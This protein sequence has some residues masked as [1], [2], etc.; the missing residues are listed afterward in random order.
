MPPPSSGGIAVAP[1]ANMLRAID[2]R[3]LGWHSAAHVHQLVEVWRRAFA[4]RN[5]LLGDPAFVTA[6]VA[7]LLSDDYARTLAATIGPRATPSLPIEP[8]I[9][10]NHTTNLC[11]VDANGTAVALT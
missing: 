3:A 1:A 7:R 8:L 2:V 9:E 4:A 5:Q 6:P 11:V 10:G